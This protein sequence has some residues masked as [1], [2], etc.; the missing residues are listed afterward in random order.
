MLSTFKDPSTVR[1][2]VSRPDMAKMSLFVAV[3]RFSPEHILYNYGS[4][5]SWQD[6]ITHPSGW[7]AWWLLDTRKIPKGWDPQVVVA[8]RKNAPF[9]ERQA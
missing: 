6:W 1:T 8:A 5:N 4:E 9:K 2:L 7:V 3:D